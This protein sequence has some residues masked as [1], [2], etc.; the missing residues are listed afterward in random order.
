MAPKIDQP[1]LSILIPTFQRA[2][3]L[4]NTLYRFLEA[5]EWAALPAGAF[6]I[7]VSDNQSS[8]GTDAV[9]AEFAARHSFIR[10]Y[11]QPIHFNSGEE[12]I[13]TAMSECK[14]IYVWT[15]SDDDIPAMSSI[16]TIFD[17]IKRNEYDFILTN[18]SLITPEGEVMRE[19]HIEC[20]CDEL[21]MSPQRLIATMGMINLSCCFSAVIYKRDRFMK[22]DWR[23]YIE[24][25]P[26]YSHVI[27]YCEAFDGGRALFLNKPVIQYRVGGTEDNAWLSRSRL[28]KLPQRFP[29]SIGLIRLLRLAQSRGA[30]PANFLSEITERDQ[31][32]AF[33]LNEHVLWELTAQLVIW[34][35]GGADYEAVTEQHIN[36]YLDCFAAGDQC[37][38]DALC[39]LQ[40]VQRVWD[41]LVIR[42]KQRGS[43]AADQSDIES[44]IQG[45]PDATQEGVAT[46][47][48]RWAMRMIAEVRSILQ[49]RRV[50]RPQGTYQGYNLFR[51]TNQYIAVEDSL[52]EIDVTRVDLDASPPSVIFHPS[53]ASLRVEIDRL[54]RDATEAGGGRDAAKSYVIR[55]RGDGYIAVRSDHKRP[56]PV[57]NN[58]WRHFPAI[59]GHRS[60]NVLY[61]YIEAVENNL[62]QREMPLSARNFPRYEVD[63]L[64]IRHYFEE[65]WYL[66]Q[67]PEVVTEI[68]DGRFKDAFSHFVE[69]GLKAGFDPSPFFHQRSALL[70]YPNVA[71]RIAEGE[72]SSWFDFY[73]RCGRFIGFSPSVYF[74]ET[75]YRRM[76][77]DVETEVKSGNIVCAFDHYLQYG[78]E[79]Q[80][81]PNMFFESAWYA[82]HKPGD[83]AGEVKVL[84]MHYLTVGEP[85]NAAPCSWFSNQKYLSLNPD[86]RA[87]VA[88]GAYRSGFHHW[89]STG[90]LQ[91]RKC[92]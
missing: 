67:Y 47:V 76:N 24:E 52:G 79:E 46:V 48:R 22:V 57:G 91:G 55:Q 18:P 30:V 71:S 61:A 13:F 38:V 27:M 37:Y 11:R 12:N 16:S 4:R 90:A 64:K 60:E 83:D 14:G 56:L 19:R 6:E 36:E 17:V 32:G 5:V 1:L 65:K 80:R 51:V 68:R 26:I 92:Q 72:F 8:D 66:R 40:K 77:A 82:E 9:V 53:L 45:L 59:L 44:F 3:L 31:H 28:L 25:S 34:I 74:D 73:L 58:V 81:I 49:A 78:I 10:Y 86:V 88:D 89:A 2:R 43:F 39:K 42:P 20:D 21:E 75:L 69:Y 41:S 85:L 70:N 15:F 50:A 35:E 62:A 7:L 54:R 84:Y 63:P 29:W 33:L 23:R 87:E